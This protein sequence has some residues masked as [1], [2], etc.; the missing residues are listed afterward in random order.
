MVERSTLDNGIRIVSEHLQEIHS[1]SLGVWVSN[2]SRHELAPLNGIS[3]FIEHMLFKGTQRRS[4]HC[5]AKEIDSVGGVLNGFTSR[6]MSCFYVKVLSEK[7]LQ[8]IDLLGDLLCHSRFDLDELEKERRVILQEIAMI[9]DN[10]EE[11]I[12]DIFAHAFWDQHPLG[13]PVIGTRESISEIS[14]DRLLKFLHERYFGKNIVIAAAGDVK[15][16][17]LVRQVEQTFCDLPT[18]G[19]V[20]EPRQPLIQRKVGIVSRPLEQTHICLGVE[21]VSQTAPERFSSFLLNTILGGNMSSRL[22]QR[23]REELGLAYSVYSYHNTHSDTGAVVLYAGTSAENAP[24]AVRTMLHEMN[25]LRQERVSE[26]ELRAAKDYL[27]GSLLLSLESS[28]NRMTRIAKNELYLGKDVPLSETQ[29]MIE[30]VTSQQ[31][32]ALAGKIFTNKTL[33]LQIV[34][35]VKPD[36]I[37]EI[38]LTLD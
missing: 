11:H 29:A 8:A 32:Q 7:F 24:L 26:D 25:V 34:G 14:R 30:A 15:H 28:D 18:D 13:Q 17:E 6:E 35:P 37:P 9:E 21:G 23:V 2:G 16:D 10:P 19:Q 20:D 3:H 4:P 1:V 33:N 22:F 5:I 31:I 27:K 36:D 38:E 12:H